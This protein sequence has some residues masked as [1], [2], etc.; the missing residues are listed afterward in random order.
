MQTITHGVPQGSTL[1]TTFFLLYV[2]EIFRT[3]PN[4]KVYTYADDT[5]LIITAATLQNLLFLA[6]FLFFFLSL[7]KGSCL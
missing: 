5:T 3:V 1:S 2:N 4:S 7:K 6:F